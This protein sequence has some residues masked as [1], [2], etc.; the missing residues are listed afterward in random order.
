MRGDLP[1]DGQAALSEH[2][3][4]CGDC[5]KRMEEIAGADIL[6]NRGTPTASVRSPLLEA[7]MRRLKSEGTTWPGGLASDP[8]LS[9]NAPLPCFGDYEIVGELG[10]GGVGVV[11]RARQMSLDRMV[12][13]KLILAGQLASPS[14]IRRFRTEAEA[15][16]R[17]DHPDIV[18]IYEVGEHEGRHYFSMKLVEGR[19]LSECLADLRSTRSYRQLALLLARITRAVHYAHQRGILHRDL[20]PGNILMDSEGRPHLTDF[21]LAKLLESDSSL[22]HSQAVMGT[23][24]YMAPELAAGRSREV[25]TA[26]DV[27]SLGAI[28][29][30][31][32]TGVPPFRGGTVGETLQN[33]LHST[34]R[35]PRSRV[36]SAPRDL[37]TI[38]LKCLEKE[39]GH[40]YPSASAVAE[41]LE[42]F[43]RGETILARPASPP[44][45]VWRWARRKPALAGLVTALHLA[46]A[47]GLTGILWQWNRANRHAEQETAQRK[48]AEESARK[49]AAQHERAELERAELLLAQGRLELPLALLASLLRENPTNHLIATRIH[50]V[51]SLRGISTLALPP[52]QHGKRIHTATYSPD[53][54]TILTAAEEPIAGLW[55]ARTGEVRHPLPHGFPVTTAAFSPEGS[56]IATATVQGTVRLWRA[57]DGIPLGPPLDH[58]RE[59][60]LL[61]FSPDGSLL[62]TASRNIIKSWETGSGRERASVQP[63]AVGFIRTVGFSPD[64]RFLV[65]AGEAVTVLWDADTLKE[66]ARLPGA[67]H[68]RFFP[69]GRWLLLNH[70]EGWEWR[71]GRRL[72]TQPEI[73]EDPPFAAEFSPDG[74]ALLMAMGDWGGRLM[75]VENFETK[76]LPLRHEQPVNDVAFSRD[77]GLMLT[78]GLGGTVSVWDTHSGSLLAMPMR[79]PTQ[80]IHAEFSPDGTRVLVLPDGLQ[81]LVWDLRLDE[82]RS[83]RFFHSD[84]VTSVRFSGDGRQ[85]LSTSR[86]GS[87]RLWETANGHE[88]IPALRHETGVNAAA[89]SPDGL[90]LATAGAD[91]ALR[92][93]DTNN[94]ERV[95]GPLEHK[96]VVS[97]VELDP[98]GKRMLTATD[99]GRA[100]VWDLSGGKELF[101][102]VQGGGLASACFSPDGNHVLTAS[103]DGTV[104]LSD[105]QTGRRVI[106]PL[107]FQDA[108]MGA[109]FSPDGQQVLIGLRNGDLQLRDRM[110]R[111]VLG[112]PMKA[113][114]GLRPGVLRFAP[115]GDRIVVASGNRAY[116]WDL[117]TFKPACPPLDH[118]DLVLD[119]R[120]SPDGSIVATA[121]RDDTARLWQVATGRPLSD[122]LPHD[123]RVECLAFSPDGSWLATGAADGCVHCW[124]VPPL[125]AEI[126]DWLPRLTEAFSR[127]RLRT[128]GQ[129][130]PIPASEA[131]ELRKTIRN[132]GR[133]G[134]YA[135]WAR[136]LLE[137]S[138]ARPVSPR[139]ELHVSDYVD[140]L[141]RSS[142][143]ECLREAVRLA[144]ANAQ[145]HAGLA[146]ALLETA[147]A[148]PPDALPEADWHSRHAQSLAPDDPK[149][150]AIRGKVEQQTSA[151]SVPGTPSPAEVGASR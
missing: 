70:W 134:D 93:W 101:A 27:F 44:E 57:S 113:P 14:E 54:S 85:V 24:D 46:L 13:L 48:R 29:Y 22:T 42:R 133:E 38:A 149:I 136:W 50:S 26:A 33:V 35:S 66:T 82:S 7:A 132:A 89:F 62:V 61:G 97:T 23:P 103:R 114:A 51:L 107:R 151:A 11:Y 32:L 130:D 94:G 64:G 12:A 16:A 3:E 28:L 76:A 137:D 21:G 65:T 126:P 122:P 138:Q 69:D 72:E 120:F 49:E 80:I 87:A 121:S 77:G 118:G 110:L 106:A 140:L 116:A 131:N 115:A 117:K 6:L 68:A 2:L 56:L 17:L 127:L 43:A 55:D 78:T 91:H 19:P 74:H 83:R 1:D 4:N 102:V 86:D 98:T 148:G 150:A 9:P 112:P 81:A 40:R 96:G 59:P 108:V 111:N 135:Q 92:V 39:P 145:A 25:T 79:H 37:E 141:A 8:A 142:R 58:D 10:R 105:A 18:P 146:A 34:P 5:R 90:L 139:S 41:E 75:N 53:G 88:T 30:E 100:N 123:S 95:L 15:A 20:K 36:P 63:G 129:S 143:L 99:A 52:L 84:V 71:E 31:F 147:A 60:A 104:L 119:A 73:G 67:R 125:A 128:A 124:E 45:R 47:L 109:V 144:P